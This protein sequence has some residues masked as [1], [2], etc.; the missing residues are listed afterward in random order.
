MNKT[1]LTEHFSLD[2]MIRSD[3]A[4][5]NCIDNTPTSEKIIVNLKSL[6]TN[7]LEPARIALNQPIHISSGYRCRTLNYM[8]GGSH[9]SQHILGQAADL[10][11]KGD[12]QYDDALWNALLST[13]FD[14]L[15]L[16]RNRRSGN[17]WIH[18]SYSPYNR[19]QI[20]KQ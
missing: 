8:V 7:V 16:E 18:V 14:Q 6:C 1:Q 12:H 10:I 5:L 15:I 13:P 2:E 17:K 11:L 4:V 19:R 3:R 9:V 20:I